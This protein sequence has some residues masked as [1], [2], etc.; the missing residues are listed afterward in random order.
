MTNLVSVTNELLGNLDE[1]LDFVGH[2]WI[3]WAGGRVERERCWLRCELRGGKL[4]TCSLRSDHVM[5]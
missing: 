1:L 4:S 5:I 3:G 2:C